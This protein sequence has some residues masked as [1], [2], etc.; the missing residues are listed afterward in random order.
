LNGVE[1]AL[2]G[3]FKNFSVCAKD[4]SVRKGDA[5]ILEFA[6]IFQIR[7]WGNAVQQS[8]VG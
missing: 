7:F 2:C 3:V 5:G 8:T 4:V 6:D 1:S